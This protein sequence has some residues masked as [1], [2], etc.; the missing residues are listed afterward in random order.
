MEQEMH[1]K[2]KQIVFDYIKPRLEKTDTHITFAIDEVY[3]VWFSKVLQN[4]KALLSTTLPDGMYYE[5]TY[6]GERRET[7]L[8]AYKKFDNVKILDEDLEPK[9]EN[10]PPPSTKEPVA[11]HPFVPGY[12]KPAE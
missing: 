10:D 12:P 6:N 9:A 1:A 11:A 8:D 5:V 2:A 7:Y 3:I 4:W